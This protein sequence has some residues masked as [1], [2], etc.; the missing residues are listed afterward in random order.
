MNF[1]SLY[2][3][4]YREG[5]IGV[6]FGYLVAS[7]LAQAEKVGQAWCNSAVNRRYIGVVPSILADESILGEETGEV[8]PPAPP[9]STSAS[10]STSDLRSKKAS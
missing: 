3:L 4:R 2:T 9:P 8:A 6:S 10:V 7:S 5:A 1:Q